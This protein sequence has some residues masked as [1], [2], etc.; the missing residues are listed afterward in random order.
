MPDLRPIIDALTKNASVT[1]IYIALIGI[2]WQVTYAIVKD[3]LTQK[4]AK[5]KQRLE[6]AKFEFEQKIENQK[7]EHQRQ[8]ET[9]KFEYEKLKWREQLALELAKCHLDAR[10]QEYPAL[11]ILARA[12]ANHKE[13]SGKLTPEK[14]QSIASEIE[15]WR[16]SK[17]GLLAEET[18]RSAAVT[19]QTALW[20]YDSSPEA[21]NRIRQARRLVRASLRAD[22]GLGSDSEGQTI[23]DATA[24]RH[25][26][27]Q[28][29]EP[30]QV[31]LGLEAKGKGD[32]EKI[33]ALRGKLNWE[34]DLDQMRTDQ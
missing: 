8:I 11:W 16:Y 21:F 6:S 10:L 13:S 7:F 2:V 31:K 25:R 20:K 34:G 22:M 18:T 19:L 32:Q 33:R 28:Q 23:F 14:C 30:L 24:E 12:F 3:I 9:V 5:L 15:V 27:I 4:D 29:L 26:I 17:G 1:V